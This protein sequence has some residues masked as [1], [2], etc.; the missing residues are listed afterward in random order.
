MPWRD[1]LKRLGTGSNLAIGLLE[2]DGVVMSQP[3]MAC[4]LQTAAIAMRKA[5]HQVRKIA[6]FR[7]AK[8]Y[9]IL[10]RVLGATISHDLLKDP[11]K[12][13]IA[14]SGKKY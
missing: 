14:Y 6:Q 7:L 10:D 2:D 5:G 11:R 8:T 1:D 3:P 13:T 9:T 4:A 12:P